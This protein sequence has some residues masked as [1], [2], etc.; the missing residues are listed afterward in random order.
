MAGRIE[1]SPTTSQEI[2]TYVFVR[3]FS[4]LGRIVGVF[5]FINKER[6]KHENLLLKSIV[7]LDIP[8]NLLDSSSQSQLSVALS[9]IS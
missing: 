7:T 8:G 5:F 1:S 3:Q 4:P 2:C 9:V 6:I